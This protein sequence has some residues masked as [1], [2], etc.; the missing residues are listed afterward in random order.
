MISSTPLPEFTDKTLGQL[1]HRPT[2]YVHEKDGDGWF[3]IYRKVA[4]GK[5][6]RRTIVTEGSGGCYIASRSQFTLER[7]AEELTKAAIRFFSQRAGESEKIIQL[8]EDHDGQLPYYTSLGGYPL[9]YVDSE[10]SGCICPSCANE[11]GEF[12]IVDYDINYEDEEMWCY[13]C[14]KQIESAYG[15]DETEE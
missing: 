9:Y 15:E 4:Y 6:I 8:R 13:Q 1:K 14:S 3:Y 11:E 7:T 2:Y 10:Y 5:H 12:P